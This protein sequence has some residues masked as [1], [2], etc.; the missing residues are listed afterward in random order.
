MFIFR[1]L[2]EQLRVER[3]KNEAL[4]AQNQ[5]LEDAVIELAEIVAMNEE[6]IQEVQNG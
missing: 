3:Q 1:D 6:A 4:Q 2:R 5:I